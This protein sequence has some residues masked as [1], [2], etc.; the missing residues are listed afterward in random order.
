MTQVAGGALAERVLM[1]MPTALDSERTA[2]L[3]RE[4]NVPSAC[5]KDIAELCRELRAGAGAVLVTD[6]SI[7]MDGA[8]QLAEALCEQPPWSAVPLLVI[9]REGFRQHPAR[10]AGDAFSRAIV[11][12]RP[13][14]TRTLCSIVLS[15]LRSRRDQYRIRDA[16]LL[17]EQQ[18]A[19]LLARDEKLRFALLAGG[20]GAW[21]LDL[22]SRELDCSEACKAHFGRTA[23]EAF[24]YLDFEETIDPLDKQR[25]LAAIERSIETGC[26][27][28]VEY[29]VVWPSGDV[30]W[31]MVRGRAAYEGGKPRRMLGVSLDIT[32]RKRMHEA[33]LQSESELARQAEE[34]RVAGRR[35]DEFLAT[36]AHEL[37]NPLAP[38]RTGLDLLLHTPGTSAVAHTLGVMQRQVG[39]MVRLI[40][41]LLDVSRI[42]RGKLEL[43]R[44]H[45]TLN[46]VLEAAVE[47]SQPLIQSR[48]HTLR[49]S[50]PESD[51]SLDADLTRMAQV[52]GNLINN[53]A[54][55][56]QPGGMIELSAR[57]EDDHALIEVRD[58][59]IGIPSERL[60]E[61]FEMFSQVN[62]TLERSQGGLGIGLALVR[63][64]VEMHGGS[65]SASSPGPGLG[66]VFAVRLPLAAAESESKRGLVRMRTARHRTR[67]RILV[68]DDNEDAADLLGMTLEQG[69]YEVKA[70]YAGAAALSLVEGWIPDIAILDIGL[71][72][73]DGYELAR[74][75]RQGSRGSPLALIALTGW[76]T[77]EDKRKATQAGFDLHLTKPVDAQVLQDALVQ[78][79]MGLAS[80]A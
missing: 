28:D 53:A 50:V 68:V 27:Y 49:V 72:N 54:N 11:V 6:E 42:T 15:A 2:F 60:D 38:I 61:V 48:R 44:A 41:D 21:D 43:K 19:E 46:S 33:L 17:R 12:E 22:G 3:L 58:N 10:A 32:E 73:M 30:R 63:S 25:V 9:A 13:V 47:A 18:A 31:V 24:S 59:G 7:A 65:V 79:E 35:K 77:Q 20:L 51:L 16:L 52:V 70:A 64:L 45:V 80:S 26:D 5:C 37:R 74:R 1:L 14:R 39:H 66:S 56:T 8:G 34:L 29:R 55:Y 40:D 57:Q 75:M 62:R 76:G 71:P 36:L 78:L 69:G 67:K 4:E 23:H